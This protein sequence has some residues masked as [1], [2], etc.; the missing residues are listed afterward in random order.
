M[1][2]IQKNE[3]SLAEKFTASYVEEAIRLM[4]RDHGFSVVEGKKEVTA[5]DKNKT[6]AELVLSHIQD[7]YDIGMNFS[8]GK[9]E[10][11]GEFYHNNNVKSKIDT[12]MKAYYAAVVHGHAFI[13][14]GEYNEVA[15]SFDANTKEVVV[16]GELV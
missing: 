8:N 10:V 1:S 15:Y 2:H 3:I 14:S 6:K 16:E 7:K 9:L 13:D 11:V 12:W 4:A 5:M